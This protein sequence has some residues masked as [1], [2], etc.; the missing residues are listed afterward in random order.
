MNILTGIVAYT[1]IW[2]VVLFTILPIGVRTA[3]DVGDRPEQGH[4]SSAPINPR[5][6]LKFLITTA[7]S[8]VIFAAYWYMVTYDPFGLGPLF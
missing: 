8:A 2:M 3:H 7:V 4:A 6:G 5:I 1:I